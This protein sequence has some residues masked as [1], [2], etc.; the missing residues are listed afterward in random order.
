MKGAIEEILRYD[1]PV[2]LTGRRALADGLE[3]QGTPIVVCR[4]LQ[5][6]WSEVWPQMRFL[7]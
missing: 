6:P 3:V 2:Q 7:S 4:G 5:G 1:S